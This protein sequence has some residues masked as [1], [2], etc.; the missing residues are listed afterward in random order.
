MNSQPELIEYRPKKLYAFEGA[1]IRM[2]D[3]TPL[4]PICFSFHT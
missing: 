1:Q 4:R 3:T 2:C